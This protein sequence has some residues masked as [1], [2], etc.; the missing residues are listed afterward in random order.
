MAAAMLE[1]LLRPCEVLLKTLPRLG[2]ASSPVWLIGPCEAAFE[3][4]H[5]SG[6]DLSQGAFFLSLFRNSGE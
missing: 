6:V 1:V 4:E 3:A 5:F 2:G